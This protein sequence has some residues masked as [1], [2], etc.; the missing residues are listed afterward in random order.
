METGTYDREHALM[1]LS[2]SVLHGRKGERVVV[3]TGIN[4]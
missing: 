4:E 2:G 1:P 3:D